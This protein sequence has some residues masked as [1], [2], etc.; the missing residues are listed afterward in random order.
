MSRMS[1]T[2][3]GGQQGSEQGGSTTGQLRDKAAEM[4]GNVRD[5]A[6]EHYENLRDTAQE[7]YDQGRQKAQEWQQ[8]LEQ[9]VQEQPIKSLLIAAG[10]GVLLG[11]IW[12]KS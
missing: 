5:A 3:S 1:D 6:T 4:V 12:K 7:Y 8:S 9:Y 11:I 10:V 2:S